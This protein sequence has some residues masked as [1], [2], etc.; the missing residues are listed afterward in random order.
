[1]NAAF[2]K[3]IRCCECGSSQNLEQHE[4]NMRIMCENCI[5]FLN[6]KLNEAS[7]EEINH[8]SLIELQQERAE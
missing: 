1:M 8:G 6:A 7:Q 2:F 5:D 4:Y 3:K